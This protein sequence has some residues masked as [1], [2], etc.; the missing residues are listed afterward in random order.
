MLKIKATGKDSGKHVG[1]VNSKIPKITV[2]RSQFLGK[3]QENLPQGVLKMGK[4]L[5]SLSESTNGVILKFEDGSTELADA[6]VACDGI[7]SVGR[8]FVLGAEH[9]AV[10]PVYTGGYN[11]RVVI[12]LDAAKESFG[13]EYCSVLTQHGWVGDGGFLL[14][15]LVD[16]G[17][18]MQVIAGWLTKETW[19]HESPFIPWPKEQIV[20]DLQDWGDIGRS[21]TKVSAAIIWK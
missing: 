8:E 6:V 5:H 20:K 3:L 7:N 12:S 4:K 17:T 19:P 10:K 21:M 11:H 16:N 13:E 15:D 2:H 18:S 1:D 14:T 9:P